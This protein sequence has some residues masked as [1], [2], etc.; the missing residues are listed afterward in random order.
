MSSSPLR[1]VRHWSH[2]IPL[3]GPVAL[4]RP[5]WSLAV[6]VGALAYAGLAQF[7]APVRLIAA[8][9]TASLFFVIS[10]VV[11]ALRASPQACRRRAKLMD[12]GAMIV[13]LL[14][15]CGVVACLLTIITAAE[16]LKLF[17]GSKGA[18]AAVV[19]VTVVLTWLVTQCTFT[20]HYAHLYYGDREGGD[21]HVG[22]L[23][24]P[25]KALPDYFDFAYFAFVL[26]MTFQ[27]SD[28]Q[29]TDRGLRRLAL[30]HGLVS[31]F[32]TTVIL[33]LTINMLAGLAQP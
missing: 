14:T 3:L 19:A 18:A 11:M 31:F 7:R 9:D 12:Q 33:A 32:F 1:P 27:V 2:R 16:D 15:L 4:T 29:I 26:G 17:A 8:W 22:G 28:V 10:V 20:L 30:L 25:G 13:L 24:F 6:L 5:R 21:E 23:D